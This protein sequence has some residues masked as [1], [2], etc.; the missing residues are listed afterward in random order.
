MAKT[1]KLVN[2][3]KDAQQKY[4]SDEEKVT[5]WNMVK[6]RGS[7]GGLMLQSLEKGNNS[8]RMKLKMT[9]MNFLSS[10]AEVLYYKGTHVS[11]DTISVTYRLTDG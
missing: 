1:F 4:A 5:N 8:L 11:P 9:V 7:K 3:L 6:T 2:N 10:H